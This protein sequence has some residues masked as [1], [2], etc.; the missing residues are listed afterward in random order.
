MRVYVG[1]G[2][3]AI[4]A[5]EFEKVRPALSIFYGINVVRHGDYVY[6]IPERKSGV[7]PEYRQAVAEF[8]ARQFGMCKEEAIAM[9]SQNAINLIVLATVLAG[10]ALFLYT[11]RERLESYFWNVL[12]PI[13][14]FGIGAYL[15]Y[16]AFKG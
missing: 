12:I 16:H 6:F 13:V 2:Y 11:Q 7:R 8:L 5:R 14:T 15:A 10:A 1:D 9:A 3:V 4:P